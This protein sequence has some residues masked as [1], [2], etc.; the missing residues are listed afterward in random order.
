MNASIAM[1]AN[2]NSAQRATAPRTSDMAFK[3]QL[4]EHGDSDGRPVG[5][6]HVLG[7]A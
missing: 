1:P 2:T 4:S 5:D 3:F 6:G 7:L